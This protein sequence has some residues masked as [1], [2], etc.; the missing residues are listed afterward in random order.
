[1]P[2]MVTRVLVI[3]SITQILNWAFL[4][5]AFALWAP[6]IMQETGW[7]GSLVF[8]GYSLSLFV[9]GLIAPFTGRLVDRHGGRPV[10]TLGTMI[11]ACGLVLLATSH[12]PVFYFC[13]FALIGIGMGSALYDPAFATLTQI[14]GPHAR[15]VISTLTLAGGF[16]ST[17]SWPLTLFLFNWFDWRMTALFY[18]C[19]LT[20]LCTPL[21]FFGLPNSAHRLYQELPEH[22]DLPRPPPVQEQSVRGPEWQAL[23]LFALVVMAHGFVTSSFSVHVIHVLD[24]WGLGETIAVSA[25]A[26]IGPAQVIARLIE[27][28]YGRHIPAL[29]LG[30]GS[31][32]LLPIAFILL[33]ASP[34]GVF[35]AGVFALFY[36][37]SNGLLTIVRGLVPLAL[38]GPEGYG[39]RLGL[40]SGPALAV[41]A[42]APMAVGAV[43][44]GAGVGLV[45]WLA[46]ACS[47]L[48]LMAMTTLFMMQ[49]SKKR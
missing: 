21:H 32:A 18:A 5:Y 14:A 27:M 8:G 30:L 15:K 44:T 46:L 3:L 20:L 25:G 49:R 48:A 23:G 29:T 17:L 33:M 9:A 2:R 35:S 38:F 11:G 22:R 37:A 16:A 39:R 4:F 45:L 1:M 41:K 40:V 6:R 24:Q 43:L 19:V 28:L 13:A 26:L 31:V 47:L 10:M 34:Q 42:I 7:S 12:D 36:G